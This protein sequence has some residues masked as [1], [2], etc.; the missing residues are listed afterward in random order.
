MCLDDFNQSA[1]ELMAALSPCRLVALLPCHRNAKA[2]ETACRLHHELCCLSG[3]L[4]ATCGSRFRP[5]GTRIDGIAK[6]GSLESLLAMLS[7]YPAFTAELRVRESCRFDSSARA[8]LKLRHERPTRQEDMYQAASS[9]ELET[10][11]GPTS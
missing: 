3:C 4:I 10:G 2:T 5:P 8:C 9:A 11:A 7:A 1:A 6:S